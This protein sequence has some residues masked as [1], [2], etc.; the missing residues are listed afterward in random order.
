[1]CAIWGGKVQIN[2]NS[3]P[4]PFICL[5]IPSTGA[6]HVYFHGFT[7]TLH[8]PQP[9]GNFEM[10]NEAINLLFFINACN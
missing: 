1:M 7:R 4:I 3:I 6:L 9:G 10:K 8:R 5:F 2:G